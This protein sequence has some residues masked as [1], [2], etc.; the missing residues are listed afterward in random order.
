MYLL[1]IKINHLCLSTEKVMCSG[2]FYWYFIHF[3]LSYCFPTSPSS[4]VSVKNFNTWSLETKSPYQSNCILSIFLLIQLTNHMAARWKVRRSCSISQA[5]VSVPQCL[6]LDSIP[7]T[8]NK[9]KWK[10]PQTLSRCSVNK[11]PHRH[12]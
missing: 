2:Y 7:I 11:E 4:V 1:H 6:A 3:P 9:R 8:P 5:L 10:E 12:N